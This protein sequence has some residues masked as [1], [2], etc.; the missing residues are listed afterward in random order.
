MG[1]KRMVMT[2]LPNRVMSAVD[3]NY[4]NDMMYLE[5]DRQAKRDAQK[6]ATDD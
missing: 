1:M 2:T 5:R 4:K 3:R 6:T